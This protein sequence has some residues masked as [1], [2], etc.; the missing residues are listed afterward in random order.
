MISPSYYQQCLEFFRSDPVFMSGHSGQVGRSHGRQAFR[1]PKVVLARRVV[2]APFQ[3]APPTLAQINDWQRRGSG[4]GL[5]IV[6]GAVS[7]NLEVIDF[8]D[9]PSFGTFQALVEE[10]PYTATLFN[11][12]TQVAT[13]NGVHAYYR[14]SEPVEGNQKLACLPVGETN[15]SGK[16]TLIETRG[17]GGYVIAA[18]NPASV[19]PSGERY[20]FAQGDYDSIP[21]ISADD[22]NLILEL[23]RS[24]NKRV[25]VA[26]EGAEQEAN[27]DPDAPGNA[28]NAQ[29]KWNDILKPEG[30]KLLYTHA[31]V[32]YWQRPG[33]DTKG[34]S[35]TVNHAGLD[36]L[37]VFSSNAQPFEPERSYSKFQAY[38]YLKYAGDFS[39]AASQLL[40]DGYGKA[41]TQDGADEDKTQLADKFIDSLSD[42]VLFHDDEDQPYADAPRGKSRRALRIGTASFRDYLSFRYFESYKKGARDGVLDLAESQ[43]AARAKWQGSKKSVHVRVAGYGQE[44][45][46]DLCNEERQVVKIDAQGW[47]ILDGDCPVSFFQPKT[48]LALP[49]PSTGGTMDELWKLLNPNLSPSDKTLIIGFLTGCL[50]PSGPFPHLVVEG[51]PGSGKTTLS[52]IIK[53]LIDPSKG[54]L[55]ALPA[56]EADL[57]IGALNSRLLAFD[58]IDTL[59]A[60]MSDAIARLSTGGGLAMRKHYSQDEEA[61]I[62]V[63]RPAIFNGINKLASRADLLSRCIVLDLPEV[64]DTSRLTE[65][66]VMR[67]LDEALPSILGALFDAVSGALKFVAQTKLSPAPRM[68]DFATWATAAGTGLGWDEG[69]FMAAFNRNQLLGAQVGLEQN[70]LAVAIMS[71]MEHGGVTENTASELISILAGQKSIEELGGKAALP[72]ANKLA[73]ELRMIKPALKAAHS[74]EISTRNTPRGT[75]YKLEKVAS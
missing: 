33:K 74:I 72:K 50:H 5:G 73:G 2:W 48:A 3:Q 25:T 27:T 49:T 70:A 26:N 63:R 44:I 18:G 8:D 23:A 58:N 32:E 40:K 75:M 4:F 28:Y 41:K 24:L 16:N 43:L 52:K 38:A 69:T 19:H 59:S 12:I 51:P 46:I 67:A 15:A 10:D 36:R 53:R 30:W 11:K 34:A 31:G 68:A 1:A 55:R 60:T 42:L 39:K 57:A 7:G 65:E 21:T 64:E 22:R 54:G 9:F 6:C 29:A 37:Y 14:C 47:S 45:Y 17:E 62:D 71:R 13:P 66:A 56:N 35:A 20:L 61:V